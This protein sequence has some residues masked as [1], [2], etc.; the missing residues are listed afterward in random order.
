MHD[1]ETRKSTMYGSV[2]AQTVTGPRSWELIQIFSF[3]ETGDKLVRLDEFF[4]SK[5]Y[6]DMIADMQK[7][8]GEGGQS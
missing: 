8:G 6:L 2:G 5:V 1:A 7:H 4:D 3:N